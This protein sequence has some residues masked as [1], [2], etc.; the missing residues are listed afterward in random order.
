[1]EKFLP[2]LKNWKES[3]E[4]REGN[5]LKKDKN[6]MFISHQTYE[7]L[8]ITV[9]SVIEAVRYLLKVPG[10]EFVMTERFNQ[11]VL[12]ENFGRHRCIGRRNENPSLFQFGYD[13][14]TT[15]MQRSIAPVTGNTKGGHKQKR[16]VS[17]S[18]VDDAPLPKRNTKS[19][20]Y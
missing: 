15:R 10:I 5:F 14:N 6:N 18:I 16:Q 8:L 3:I 12:E 17:W 1:M 7:G 20:Q 4:S 19:D 13:S 2:Y 11:D 9:H